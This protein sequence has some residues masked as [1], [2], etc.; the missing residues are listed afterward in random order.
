METKEKV[1]GE[2]AKESRDPKALKQEKQPASKAAVRP[3]RKPLL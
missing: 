1:K 2:A 3:K